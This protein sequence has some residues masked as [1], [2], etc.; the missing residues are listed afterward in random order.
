[1]IFVVSFVLIRRIIQSP[2][3]RV[4]LAIRDNPN[5]SRAV[6]YNITLYK[7][8]PS[9]SP[10]FTG[11]AGGLF[12]LFMKMVPI[13]AIELL[14]YTDFIIMILV[15]GTG[16]LYGPVIGAIVTQIASEILGE[17]WARWFF[18]QGVI[19]VAIVLFMRGDLGPGS[20][21]LE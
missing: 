10:A 3:G 17:P 11:L 8:L 15:G 2:F 18:I 4:L 21:Q 7:P 6:G 12:A 1:M 5:R 14:T 20:G 13:T 19:F 16:S 9:S